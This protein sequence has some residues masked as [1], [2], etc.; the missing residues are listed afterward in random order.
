MLRPRLLERFH[1]RSLIVTQGTGKRDRR[2][3]ELEVETI[4][5][6]LNAYTSREQT[7]FY[8]KVGKNDVGQVRRVVFAHTLD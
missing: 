5:G 3:L 7:V 8:A 4:G 1:S 6:H 2:A